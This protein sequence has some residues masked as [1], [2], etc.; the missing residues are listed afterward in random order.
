MSRGNVSGGDSDEQDE[1]RDQPDLVSESGEALVSV[2]TR[3]MAL[4]FSKFTAT[5]SPNSMAVNYELRGPRLE[6]FCVY[7]YV[8]QIGIETVRSARKGSFSFYPEHPKFST[9][10]QYSRQYKPNDPNPSIWVPVIHGTLTRISNRGKS[11]R[12]ILADSPKAENDI[13]ECLLGLF[14]PWNRFPQL[15]KEYASDTTLFPEPRDACSLIWSHIY[16]KLHPR[17]QKLSTNLRLLRRSKEAA[18]KDR[19]ARALE[20]DLWEENAT[21][22][23][24]DMRYQDEFDLPDIDWSTELSTEDFQHGFL[25]AIEHWQ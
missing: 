21:F 17:L 14:V 4:G 6:E 2:D 7:E 10:R 1:S 25:N 18:E 19:Q 9:Y 16:P 22:G 5:G 12:D 23:V 24:E 20:R 15:F 3:N 11:A 8:A 13:D